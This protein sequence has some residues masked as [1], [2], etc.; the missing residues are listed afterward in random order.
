MLKRLISR[1]Q[2]GSDEDWKSY[3][4]NEINGNQNS[5][6]QNGQPN[7]QG[8]DQNGSRNNSGNGNW[9]SNG[10]WDN[11]GS[12]NWNSNSGWDNNGNGNW[13]SNGGWE[14]NGN[15]NWNGN[16]GWDNNGSGNWNGNG[17]W[18]NNG[19]GNWSGNSG[20][21][22]SGNE[23]WN[24]YPSYTPYNAS[25]NLA[26]ASFV[27]SIAALATTFFMTFFL[28]MILAPISIVLAIISKGKKK[29]VRDRAKA[30]VFI[31][32]CA[33]VINF[34]ILVNSFVT[35]FRSPEMRA[36]VNQVTEQMYGITV[37][38]TIREIDKMYGTNL[39][40]LLRGDSSQ[41]YNPDGNENSGSEVTVTGGDSDG[42][43]I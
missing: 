8:Q 39:E 36:T 5:Q 26:Q 21:D 17:G 42:Q 2:S 12:R 24:G 19:S 6:D 29:H 18:D 23:N 15:G 38:D 43:I 13:N 34:S 41:Y 28:P 10:G 1:D 14:N 4:Q 33:L 32:V 40:S 37:E 27:L 7:Q 22:S 35:L 30:A 3:W 25:Q 31:S 11:N 16:S 9:N 20:W